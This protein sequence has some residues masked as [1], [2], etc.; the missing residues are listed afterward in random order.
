ML[1]S[2][3]E[4]VNRHRSS[5]ILR[6]I[7]ILAILLAGLIVFVLMVQPA[8]ARQPFATIAIDARTGKVLYS[9]AGDARRYPASLTKIMTLYL[10]FEDLKAGRINLNTKLRVSKYAAS[11]PPSKLGFKPG[12][13]IRVKDAI[14]A[15]V[16]KSANDVATAVAENLSG[17]ESAFARRMTRKARSLG[18]TRTTFKNAS[19]LPDSAQVT[20]ARD[21]ATLAIRIQKDFPKK[22]RYFS[23][24]SY[25]Y[26]RRN[27]RN[28]NR[29]LGRTHG[30]DG[31]KTGY[32]RASGYNLVTS[33]R[34][35]K[36]RIIAVVMGAKSGGSRNRYMA[37]L[38]NRM[39]KNKRLKSGTHLANVAGT[40]PG[41]RATKVAAVKSPAPPLPRIKPANPNKKDNIGL[42]VAS[43]TPA[44][45]KKITATTNNSLAMA[46]LTTSSTSSLPKSYPDPSEGD[47]PPKVQMVGDKPPSA[48]A[49]KTKVVAEITKTETALDE[50][51]MEPHLASWNIQIGAFPTAD[52]AQSRLQK[53]MKKATAKLRGKKPFTMKFAKGN[54]VYYRARFSGFTR[55]SAQKA[56]RALTSRGVGCFALAPKI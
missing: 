32:T 26:G 3:S 22:Y 10:V 50:D 45:S 6:T 21:M 7:D 55:R 27:Y 44:I 20:T 49:T 56:C 39:F 51:V 54:N 34:R 4:P 2:V 33:A 11:R 5:F 41:Y 1:L 14:G 17:S 36:K 18:M 13:T 35:N 28:H 43:Q 52:G 9:K 16:T 40:P 37:S 23:M 24:R 25:K 30:V 53:A 48:K 15:L 29:L 12:G 38:V 47:G 8:S 42:V 31:I 19:G 46:S